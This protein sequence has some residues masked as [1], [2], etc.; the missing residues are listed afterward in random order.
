[1]DNQDVYICQIILLAHTVHSMLEM[2][3][4]RM[5]GGMYAY[6]MLLSYH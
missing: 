4:T 2:D 1:M 6:K 5:R 3:T